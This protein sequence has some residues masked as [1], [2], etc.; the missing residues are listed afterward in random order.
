[1]PRPRLTDDGTTVTPDLHGATVDEGLRLVRRGAALAAA[2]G[3]ATLR[4]VHG[5]ST[6]DPRTRNRTL[7]H[8]LHDLL[9]DDGL[10]E[11]HGHFAASEGVTVVSLGLPARR[12]PTPIRML[13]LR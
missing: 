4:V 12:D 6:S 8:A 10:P 11:A 7:K 5:A 2:R 13:D 1:M 9:D 3:R